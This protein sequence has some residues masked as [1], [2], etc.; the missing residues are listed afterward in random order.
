MACAL[1]S[2]A[3]AR[4]GFVEEAAIHS[5]RRR[6]RGLSVL[7]REGIGSLIGF[8][9]VQFRISLSRS[10]YFAKWEPKEG[11]PHSHGDSSDSFWRIRL[12]TALDQ[13]ER[14]GVDSNGVGESVSCLDDVGRI[15]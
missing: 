11:S 10:S 6:C 15:F 8:P 12:E 9:L 2:T 4:S 1:V 3:E 5:S 14:R 13:K 7:K